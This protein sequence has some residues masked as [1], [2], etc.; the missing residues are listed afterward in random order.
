MRNFVEFKYV[1]TRRSNNDSFYSVIENSYAELC[2][3]ASPRYVMQQQ[4]PETN[5]FAATNNVSSVIMNLRYNSKF[6]IQLVVT[7]N[8]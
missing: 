3:S 4:R 2:K 6:N 8:F 5:T 7:I 1:W